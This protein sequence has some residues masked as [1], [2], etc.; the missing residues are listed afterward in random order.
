MADRAGP[1]R[2]PSIDSRTTLVPDMPGVL[3]NHVDDQPAQ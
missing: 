3:L 2:P 1:H